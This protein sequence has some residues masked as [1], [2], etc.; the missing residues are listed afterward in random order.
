[1]LCYTL[2]QK[3]YKELFEKGIPRTLENLDKI[4]KSC[5]GKYFAG[6]KVDVYIMVINS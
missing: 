3:L 1:M 2:Q 4:L 5:D 6:N